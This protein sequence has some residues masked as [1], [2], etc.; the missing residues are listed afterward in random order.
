[1]WREER[2]GRREEGKWRKTILHT[3]VRVV[4]SNYDRFHLSEHFAELVSVAVCYF[5]R[6]STIKKR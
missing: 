2:S 1:M 6:L 4:E 5:L 3:R